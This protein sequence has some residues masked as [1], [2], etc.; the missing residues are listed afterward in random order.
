MKKSDLKVGMLV[1]YRNGLKRM[2]MPYGLVDC[3]GMICYYLNHYRED[4]IAKRDFGLGYDIVKVYDIHDYSFD[5]KC[6]ERE[7]LWERNEQL[8]NFKIGDKVKMIKE[9]EDFIDAKVGKVYIVSEENQNEY[10]I[11]GDTGC[12][13]WF[14]KNNENAGLFEK[15]EEIEITL[16]EIAAC[17]NVDVSQ[18][19]IKK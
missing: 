16:D 8:H 14:F 19:K 10:G 15:V 7:L 13:Q 18:L 17:F 3:D 1:E 12:K 11:L 6:R 5:F 9:A 4:L 2:V